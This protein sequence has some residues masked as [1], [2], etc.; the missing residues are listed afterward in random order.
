MYI[1]VLEV[2]L[3]HWLAYIIVLNMRILEMKPQLWLTK[4]L[5]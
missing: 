4:W 5:W 3:R 2:I 1:Y